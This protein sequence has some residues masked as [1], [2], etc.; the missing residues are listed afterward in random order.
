MSELSR[1]ELYDFLEAKHDEYNRPGFIQTD[2]IQIPHRFSKKEDI[3]ISAFLTSAIAWG[4][5]GMIIRSADTMLK[6]MGNNPHEFVLNYSEDDRLRAER[7]GHRT[8]KSEDFDFFIRALQNIYIRY[9]GLQKVFSD[10]FKEKRNMFDAIQGFRKI[11]LQAEH[12]PRSEKHIA[13]PA[14]NSAAK[15]LNMFLMWMVRNDNRGVHFGLWNKIPSSDLIIPM[16]VHCGNTARA[17]GLLSRKQNDRKAAEQLTHILKT[18]D[19]KDPVK[20]DFALF[21]AGVFEGFGKHL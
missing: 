7:V 2:P 19:S 12:A 1:E 11:F 9:G 8:F 21:G 4:K 18:F 3:E 17:L 5:R 13:N 14:K 16:D 20:Y 6:A 15:R 10:A